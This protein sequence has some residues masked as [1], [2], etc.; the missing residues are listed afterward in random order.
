MKPRKKGARI[1][2]I[3]FFPEVEVSEEWAVLAFVLVFAGIMGGCIY[4]IPPNSRQYWP[5]LW[6]ELRDPKPSWKQ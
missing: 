5:K 2:P 3:V 4:A 1:L 6:K